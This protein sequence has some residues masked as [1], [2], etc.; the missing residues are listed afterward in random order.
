MTSKI[1]AAA[2]A[3]AAAGTEIIAVNPDKGPVS[4]EGHYDEAVSVIGLLGE[5]HA[6]EAAA[7]TAT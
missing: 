2:P 5:V 4:I 1:G 3:A 6:G 7:S